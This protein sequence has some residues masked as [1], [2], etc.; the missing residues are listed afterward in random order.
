MPLRKIQP[1][2]PQHQKLHYQGF[3]CLSERGCW[4]NSSSWQ[5]FYDKQIELPSGRFQKSVFN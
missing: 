1:V 4:S 3:Q 5:K 2:Q